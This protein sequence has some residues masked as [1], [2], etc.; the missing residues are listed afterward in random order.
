MEAHVLLVLLQWLELC[1]AVPSRAVIQDLAEAT[2]GT[3]VEY[4]LDRIKGRGRLDE[5]ERGRRGREGVL[6]VN[7]F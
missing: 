2:L 1:H 4:T 3:M 6:M 7:L 5:E